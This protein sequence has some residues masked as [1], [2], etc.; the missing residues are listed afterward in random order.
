MII[1]SAEF[2]SPPQQN[3]FAEVQ[4]VRPTKLVLDHVSQLTA[5]RL[6]DLGKDYWDMG[7]MTAQAPP[8][9]LEDLSAADVS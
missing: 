9:W 7:S 6:L 1:G 2:G 8:R 3:V 4:I 5:L